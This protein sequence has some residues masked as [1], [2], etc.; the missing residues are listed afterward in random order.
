M[1]ILNGKQ[2]LLCDKYKITMALRLQL[3]YLNKMNPKAVTATLLTSSF[4]SLTCIKKKKKKVHIAFD[5][6][7]PNITLQKG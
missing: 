6:N 5:H 4:T 1:A 2:G 3:C 7:V